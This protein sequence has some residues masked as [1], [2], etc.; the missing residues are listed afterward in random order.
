MVGNSSFVQLFKC[1]SFPL[2]QPI[3]TRH[4]LTLSFVLTFAMNVSLSTWNA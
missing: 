4:L 1:V 3:S 2:V